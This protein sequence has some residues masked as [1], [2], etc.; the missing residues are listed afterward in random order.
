MYI[1]EAV[2]VGPSMARSWL[3]KNHPNN[4]NPKPRKVE[5]YS[6]DMAENLW[7]Y[8]TGELIKFDEQGFMV[9]GQNRM[10]A[11]IKAETSVQFDVAY[12]VPSKAKYVL[13][14]GA[15][16]SYAD[17]LAFQGLKNR[18]NVG[19]VVRWI[20]A[21]EMGMPRIS[22]GSVQP[23]HGEMEL[24]RQEEPLQFEAST[25]RGL[26]VSRQGICNAAA[27]GTAHFL[28]THLDKEAAE[29]FFDRLVSG[30]DMDRTNPILALRN[31]LIRG[32]HG[33]ERDS[34]QD[35]LALIIRG[36]NAWREG[37]TLGNVVVSR[38]GTLTNEN[39]PKP[40]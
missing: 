9:D 28:F 32:R 26:D 33:R 8:P 19:A 11:V 21:W 20:I 12:D 24:R 37:R 1:K 16:R 13:D 30:S 2:I 27:A 22:G 35:Q 3:D 14:S 29:L 18:N 31:R 10:L 38:D 23:T 7:I 36:W 40:R 6:R 4:R 25:S 5:S 39:F 34:R 15:G 17:A